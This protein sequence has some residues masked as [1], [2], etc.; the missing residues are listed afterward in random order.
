MHDE[1]FIPQMVKKKDDKD[2]GSDELQTM[3]QSEKWRFIVL[4]GRIKESAATL[5]EVHAAMAAEWNQ[6][7]QPDSKYVFALFGD[8]KYLLIMSGHCGASS[9]HPC[10]HCV[11]S[12]VLLV[13]VARSAVS[14]TCFAGATKLDRQRTTKATRKRTKDIQ[15]D[16]DWHDTDASL[17]SGSWLYPRR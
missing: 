16:D 4:L 17:P 14:L 15:G 7:M 13:P 9:T 6:L 3:S 8:L 10:P 11:R 2:N 1:I 5:R 12:R